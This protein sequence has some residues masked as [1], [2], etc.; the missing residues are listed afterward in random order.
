MY[1]VVSRQHEN[2]DL[3]ITYVEYSILKVHLLLC[4]FVVNSLSKVSYVMYVM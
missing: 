1:H 2:W 3:F 4:L